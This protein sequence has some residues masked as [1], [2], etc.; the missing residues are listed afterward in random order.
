MFPC[1]D[2]AAGF[3]RRRFLH[4]IGGGMLIATGSIRP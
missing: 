4:G 1:V 2:C 3:S